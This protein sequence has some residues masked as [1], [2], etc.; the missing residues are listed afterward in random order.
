MRSKW[1][2]GSDSSV[3]GWKFDSESSISCGYWDCLIPLPHRVR[4]ETEF[5]SLQGKPNTHAW[6]TIESLSSNH[7]LVI[8][9]RGSGPLSPTIENRSSLHPWF[10]VQHKINFHYN[11][12]SYLYERAGGMSICQAEE[13]LGLPLTHNSRYVANTF[14]CLTTITNTLR[15]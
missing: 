10:V 11:L 3:Q 4:S 6:S 1:L 7:W 5:Q 12:T 14:K 9:V 15:P 8:P 13:L 2:L